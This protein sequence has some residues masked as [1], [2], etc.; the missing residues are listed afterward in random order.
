[1]K[2]YKIFLSDSKKRLLLLTSILIINFIAFINSSSIY[3]SEGIAFFTFIFISVVTINTREVSLFRFYLFTI[4]VFLL[5]QPFANLFGFFEYP[6]DNAI[7]A[8]AGIIIPVSDYTLSQSIKLVS[9]HICFCSIG[10]WLSYKYSFFPPINLIKSS[11]LNVNI[12]TNK[13]LNSVISLLLFFTVFIGMS[14]YSYVMLKGSLNFGYTETFHL[15]N[16]NMPRILRVFELLYPISGSF[17]LYNSRT[18]R[19]YILRSTIF[20]LPYL[21]IAISGQRGPIMVTTVSLIY[22]FCH[23]KSYIP[24]M[25]LIVAGTSML[26]FSSFLAVFRV[27]RDFG[28]AI[29][30]I[31]DD[32][33]NIVLLFAGEIGSSLGVIS[34]TMDNIQKF[35]NS[36]PFLLGYPAAV[37][38]FEENYTFSALQSKSYLSQHLTYLLDPQKLI[39]GST[40]GSSIVAE[41]LEISDQFYLF[42]GIVSLAITY[43]ILCFV[44]KAGSSPIFFFISFIITSSYLFSPRG[45][46][47]SFVNK[48]FVITGTICLTYAI[49]KNI[50]K[51]SEA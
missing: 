46:I 24:A 49:L 43:F 38:N 13:S 47:F 15:G 26:L 30:T 34:Y 9:L 27:Y 35:F 19:G 23:Q 36:T 10:W 37:F 1:M 44:R 12:N 48:E 41:T 25:R 11:F 16:I 50:C 7:F 21:V 6:P 22:L 33:G 14:I 18:T 40:I 20:I 17:F 4:L 8:L 32:I 3:E 5:I 39:R 28:Y 45:S 51:S 31:S 42:G 2:L 29:N